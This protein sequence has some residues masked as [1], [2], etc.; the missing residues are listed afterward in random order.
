MNHEGREDGRANIGVT[1]A[2]SEVRRLPLEPRQISWLRDASA[3]P[4]PSLLH[5]SQT[6]A[7]AG[8]RL[9]IFEATSKEVSGQRGE[10]AALAMILQGRTRARISS[11]GDECD[12]S[13]G[14]D[15]V[16]L[17]APYLDISWTRWDCEPGA[18]RMMI[19]L[20]FADLNRA[21]DLDAMLARQPRV[22]RQD[23]TMRDGHIAALMRLVAD[24][25]R[26]GSPHGSLYATS[27]SLGLAAYLFSEKGESGSTRMRERGRLTASQKSHVL[28]LVQQRLAEDIALDD[29]AAAAGVSRFHFLRLFKNSLGMT[30]HRFVMDQRLAAARKLLAETDQQLAD[31]AANTGFSSQSHLCT[32][33]RR[34][35]GVTPKQWRRSTVK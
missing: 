1:M 17:F 18:Q 15:S 14:P 27:L 21:G 16:G 11:H 4:E 10:H 31:V 22:L 35:L 5:E 8:F 29:L 28:D 25:V 12:F 26:L 19:E 20:D 24:E 7:W 23:L 3:R 9:G 33:M 30:P 2:T 34:R 32:S 6:A 13:P